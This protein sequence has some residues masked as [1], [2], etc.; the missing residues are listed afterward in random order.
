VTSLTDKEFAL[1]IYCLV[2]RVEDDAYDANVKGVIEAINSLSEREIIALE[3]RYRKN[4]LLE[5]VGLDIGGVTGNRAL[6]V[7]RLALRRLRHPDTLLKMSISLMEKDRDMCRQRLIHAEDVV[8]GLKKDI[9]QLSGSLP[10]NE[11]QKELC[12]SFETSIFDT[13]FTMRAKKAFR[14]AKK[15]TVETVLEIT[16]FRE[17]SEIRNLGIKSCID[18]ITKM[19]QMG[20]NQWAD[21]MAAG[22]NIRSE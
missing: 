13:D 7:L 4:N 21:K 2:F 5:K 17:L 3:S 18:V 11:K 15:L 22:M 19:R 9:V 8:K 1:R 6:Q 14:F 12:S 10:T 20:F 16:S